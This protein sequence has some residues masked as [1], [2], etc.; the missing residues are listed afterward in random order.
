LTGLFK[1]HN[2]IKIENKYINNNE[3]YFKNNFYLKK[4]Y[5]NQRPMD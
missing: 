3:L 5:I 1:D 4:Y 2:Y